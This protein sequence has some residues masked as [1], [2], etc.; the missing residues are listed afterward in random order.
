MGAAGAPPGG[1][2]AAAEVLVVTPAVRTRPHEDL[3]ITLMAFDRD[4]SSATFQVFVEPLVVWIWLGGFII[5]LGALI[6]VWPPRRRELEPR[7][8]ATAAAGQGAG[9]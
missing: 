8:A 4:G 5:G 1:R 7:T 6:A 3:Y 2:A 9:A